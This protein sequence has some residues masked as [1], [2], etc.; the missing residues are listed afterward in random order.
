MQQ[1]IK[2]PDFA[3][4]FT[5]S[6]STSTQLTMT[7]SNMLL[8]NTLK[9]YFEYTMV[10]MCGIPRIMM[11]GT[12][13]DWTKLKEFYEYFKKFFK[14]SELKYW[15]NQFDIIMD[16]FITMR[17]LKNSGEVEAPEDIK[18]LFKR[19]ISHIPYGSGGGLLLGGWIHLLV[20]YSSDNKLIDFKEGVKF[21]DINNNEPVKNTNYYENKAILKKYY[22][23]KKYNSVQISYMTTP[24]KLNYYGDEHDVEF[25]SGFYSPHIVGSDNKNMF[26]EFN[27]GYNMKQKKV[28]K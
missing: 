1:N 16:M 24:A 12:Q 4:M 22:M 11:E 10:C 27:I 3:K 6:Y 26:V 21:L 17:M 8:M 14:D 5:T 7:V 2:D 13:E 19:V 15:F 28:S 25:N 9:E 23:A 20:P 18:I